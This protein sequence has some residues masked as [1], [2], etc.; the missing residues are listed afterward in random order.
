M[1]PLFRWT[2]GGCI[3]QGLDIM[4][5]SIDRTTSALGEDTFDWMI[6]YNGLNSDQ[7]SFLKDAVGS[8]PIVLE[9]QNWTD[10]AIPDQ[11][12][13]PARQDGSFEWNG[14]ICGGTLW[15]VAPAR[16]RIEVH[17]IVMDNDIVM[18]KAIPMIEE[19]LSSDKVMILEEPIRFY[20]AYDKFHD[21][22]APYLNSGF[23]GF[24]P[25][26][27]FGAAIRQKWED[28]T[29]KFNL[30]QAD[31]QGL[32]MLTLKDQPNI[33]VGV[34]YVTEILGKDYNKKFT[35]NEYSIHFTQSNK[36]PNHQFWLQYKQTINGAVF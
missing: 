27:D 14:N 28:K 25:G 7:L 9:P 13:S 10:C 21:S 16:K 17:E 19:F 33:R 24:P 20:G 11:C 15:K 12:Q 23:M 4:A 34:E 6:C 26:Y 3:Q 22:G 31:E 5:E 29:P 2:V 18:L 8:R 32:L 1:K 35:G 30:S 36:M